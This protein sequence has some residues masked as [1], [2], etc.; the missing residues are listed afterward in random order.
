MG[1]VPLG[2]PSAWV[3][4]WPYVAR[5]WFQSS[6]VI[7]RSGDRCARVSASAMVRKDEGNSHANF[8]VWSDGGVRRGRLRR[9]RYGYFPQGS[10]LPP[11]GPVHT[12]STPELPVEVETE[13]APAGS[14]KQAPL[15]HEVAELLD[16]P[17]RVSCPTP[18]DPA[19]PSNESAECI[20]LTARR[21]SFGP[22]PLPPLNVW[23]PCFNVLTGQPLRLRTSDGE[24]SWDQPGKLYGPDPDNN[25]S[26][27]NT[28]VIGELVVDGANNLV[29]LN[30]TFD[31]SLPE[32]G[33]WIATPAC[34]GRPIAAFEK[35]ISELDF[36]RPRIS[37]ELQEVAAAR[38]PYVGRRASQ[39]LGKALFWDMQVGSDGVQACATCHFH[40]GTD[41][42]TKNQLNPNHLGGDLTLQV[43]ANANQNL[44]ASD[45][46][47]H[48]LV[49]PDGPGDPSLGN[50]ADDKNDVVSSMGV[51]FREF[52][53]IRPIGN[54]AG[55]PPSFGP[56]FM[57]VRP[58]LPDLSTEPASGPQTLDP[59]PV[60]QGL[61]RVEPRNT[62]T[63]FGTAF[64]F[65]NFWDGRARHDSNGGSVF[66]PTDPQFHVF[67]DPDEP[68][69]GSAGHD[70]RASPARPR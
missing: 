29:F 62:P 34:D 53:D 21:P 51:R 61:R 52:T 69:G 13:L 64:N 5:G 24:I 8:K 59:I 16:H 68:G 45:F 28:N 20:A 67:I 31:P 4:C 50:V 1:L 70:Q 33:D 10:G 14:L 19:T 12:T 66:G 23:S 54:Q 35:P 22:N 42:R 39:V 48:K 15:W 26:T 17:N 55:Q 3:Q 2:S 25:P 41:N 63:I 44:V 49:N 38:R 7:R 27:V 18:D 58:L 37:W 9:G 6:V 57:D 65:D 30:P 11:W 40:A 60:M 32:D 56:A 46:P 43:H 47:F 36:L